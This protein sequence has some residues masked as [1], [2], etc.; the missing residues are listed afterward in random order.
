MICR[1]HPADNSAFPE[2]DIKCAVL[3][4]QN[5]LSAIFYRTFVSPAVW[6]GIKSAKAD[7]MTLKEI[8]LKFSFEKFNPLHPSF[9]Y[10]NQN[11]RVNSFRFNKKEHQPWFSRNREYVERNVGM[12]MIVYLKGAVK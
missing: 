5:K 1:Y 11:D 6:E 4:T 10:H 2:N 7:G 9:T 3:N 8:R 12:N